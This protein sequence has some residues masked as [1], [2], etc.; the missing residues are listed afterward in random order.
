MIDSRYLDGTAVF[1]DDLDR[2]AIEQWYAAEE[3]GFYEIARRQGDRYDEQANSCFDAMNRQLGYAHLG[4]RH[5]RH[6]LAIG[7]ANGT[8]LEPIAPQVDR[9]TAIEPARGWW[10]DTIAGVPARYLAPSIERLPLDDAEADLAVCFGSLHHI[11]NIT[12][13]LHDLAR[14]LE[15]GGM[16]ILREPIC[17]MGDWTRP[18]AGLTANERGFPAPWLIATL[19]RAGFAVIKRSWCVFP[20]VPRLARLL[21]QPGYGYNSR[22]LTLLDRVLSQAFAWNIHYHRDRAFKKVAP[23]AIQIVARKG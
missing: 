10:R 13:T 15:P 20:A 7:C 19:Q 6:C 12:Q 16:L 5:F 22:A 23:S 2:A 8:E 17:T 18:R 21:R 9:F 4:T 3:R 11:P 1:G 14:V